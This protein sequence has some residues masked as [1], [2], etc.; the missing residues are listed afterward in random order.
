MSKIQK[1]KKIILFK[2]Q[3]ETLGYFSEQLAKAFAEK[4][5][6]VYL[7]DF[8]N[9]YQGINDLI[10]FC[11]KENTVMITFNFIGLNNE[12]IFLMENGEFFWNQREILC[13]NIIV[14]HPF[15]Y[16][17]FFKKP[18]LRYILFC[19]DQNHVNYM[20]RFFP[21]LKNVFFL[22][23]AGTQLTDR[24][25]SYE[26]RKYDIIFTG[27]YTPPHTFD[28]YIN[29]ID[30][31]YSLFYHNIIDNL[32]NNPDKTIEEAIEYQTRLEINDLTE[33]DLK[34]AMASMIF[35]DLYVRFY[36][37]ALA[38]QT[39][40]DNGFRVD[41]FGKG[42]D[43]LECRN[44]NNLVIHGGIESHECILNMLDSRISLNV[45]PWFKAGAHDRIFNTM[46]SKSVSLS[47][48]STYIT[49]Q[50]TEE[51]DIVLYS[52]A[53]MDKLPAITGD[54]LGNPDKAADIAEAGF[55]K[56][57]II[58]TWKNRAETLSMY[59]NRECFWK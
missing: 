36:F 20:K 15:Y 16:H 12:D 56:S 31:D 32:I 9:D 22:P 35:I 28:K 44:K 46:L 25:I 18:P 24:F 55:Q 29:R 58:H 51:S 45:M 27:N 13:V 1:V 33:E 5:Y 42:W 4:G 57:R 39:L 53:S 7:F 2:G 23:L 26:E 47:D 34:N 41:V 37:R 3:I 59:I 50:F 19:V 11:E 8:N 43:L 40:V 14:D 10:W 30:D 38:V 52:L 17:E 54:L 6:E 49:E 48:G 21:D